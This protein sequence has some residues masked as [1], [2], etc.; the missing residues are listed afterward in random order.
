MNWRIGEHSS[1]IFD[2][3]SN[4]WF[5][6]Y[7]SNK[8]NSLL[9][10][11]FLVNVARNIS[12]KQNNELWTCWMFPSFEWCFL[13]WKNVSKLILIHQVEF[14]VYFLYLSYNRYQCWCCVTK[15]NTKNVNNLYQIFCCWKI[16]PGNGTKRCSTTKNSDWYIAKG[17]IVDKKRLKSWMRKTKS[18]NCNSKDCNSNPMQA[19]F[20]KRTICYLSVNDFKKMKKFY[21]LNENFNNKLILTSKIFLTPC[22][23]WSL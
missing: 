18:K 1:S 13:V 2:I 3:V 22:N 10:S 6:S 15:S 7:Y 11:L 5:K 14:Y 9:P 8:W 23:H 21:C 4:S 16:S 20:P 19:I 17:K 12:W